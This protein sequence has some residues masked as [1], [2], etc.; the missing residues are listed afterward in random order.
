MGIHFGINPITARPHFTQKGTICRIRPV[1]V[2]AYHLH[3]ILARHTNYDDTFGYLSH[4]SRHALRNHFQPTEAFRPCDFQTICTALPTHCYWRSSQHQSSPWISIPSW[5]GQPVLHRP[6]TPVHRPGI[7]LQAVQAE[8]TPL[9]QRK[10]RQWLPRLTLEPQP[11]ST[12]I[13]ITTSLTHQ[14]ISKVSCI[15]KQC[16]PYS[17][18]SRTCLI[19]ST[20]RL[21]VLASPGTLL[22][23]CQILDSLHTSQWRTPAR[24]TSALRDPILLRHLRRRSSQS[25]LPT[26]TRPSLSFAEMA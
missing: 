19:H 26:R 3:S 18:T 10:R 25:G 1:E 13:T 12:T 5:R 6:V 2:R 4:A 24:A 17:T 20:S 9:Y 22:L 15:I 16:R 14:C 8:T 21:Q 23:G 11:V 7:R